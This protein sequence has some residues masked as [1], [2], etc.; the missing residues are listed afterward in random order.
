MPY[1]SPILGGKNEDR[2]R[3]MG[4]R[5]G[6]LLGSTERRQEP[7]REAVPS[8]ELLGGMRVVVLLWVQDRWDAVYK[9][10][11]KQPLN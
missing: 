11:R 9:T 10:E 5:G 8:S 4:E 3:E 2:L 6:V 7:S 1:L